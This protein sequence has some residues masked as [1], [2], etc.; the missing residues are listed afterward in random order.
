MSFDYTKITQRRGDSGETDLL[1]GKKVA[2][3]ALV[4][5]AVGKGDTVNTSLGVCHPYLTCYKDGEKISD[6]IQHIQKTLFQLMGEL[7]TAQEDMEKY[8]TQFKP[9]DSNNLEYLEDCISEYGTL[10]NKLTVG[11]SSGWNVYGTSGN[12]AAVFMHFANSQVREWELL[13][14]ELNPRDVIKKYVNRLSKVLFLLA[15]Y[16]DQTCLK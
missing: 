9:I 16:L 6:I 1:F 4:I 2:K 10:L 5:R 13:I 7:S 3:T 8:N 15:T 12:K 11:K 14:L